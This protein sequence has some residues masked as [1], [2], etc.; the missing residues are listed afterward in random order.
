MSAQF[1]LYVAPDRGLIVVLQNDQIE[2]L[3]TR[4]FAPCLPVGT[5]G[6]D[7][8]RLTPG[9]YY[10]ERHYRVMTHLLGVTRLRQLGTRVGSI[11]HLR[12]EITRA[13]DLL[14]TGF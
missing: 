1:D 2:M 5:G 3:N 6:I 7:F 12:D 13:M 9:F 11:A 8:P 10:A 4:V 14:M